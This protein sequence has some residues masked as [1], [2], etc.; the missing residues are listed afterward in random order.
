M[1]NDFLVTKLM[2]REK[3]FQGIVFRKLFIKRRL[4]PW[5]LF[6]VVLELPQKHL[7]QF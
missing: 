7:I 1:I 2:K 4:S 6:T 5:V 3:R